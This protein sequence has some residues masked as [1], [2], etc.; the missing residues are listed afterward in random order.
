MTNR[1][2]RYQ[3]EVTDEQQLYMPHSYEA[4]SVAPSRGG[5]HI[6][7]WVQ[8]NP[9]NTTSAPKFYVVG[10]GNPMPDRELD[11]VGTAVMS[12]GLVWHVFAERM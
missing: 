5:Y 3:L 8:V 7:L 6:D 11:F 4:L 1:I 2:F 12:D 9:D 10:T